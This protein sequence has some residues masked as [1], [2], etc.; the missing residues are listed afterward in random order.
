MLKVGCSITT[1]KLAFSTSPDGYWLVAPW[2]E[3]GRS[4][5]RLPSALMV[6][7]AVAR[8]G[9]STWKQLMVTLGLKPVSVCLCRR[10]TCPGCQSV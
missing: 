10:R 4:W 5:M 9:P 6:M 3:S 1:L 7:L 2:S 8:F